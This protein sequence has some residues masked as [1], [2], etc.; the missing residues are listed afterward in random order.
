MNRLLLSFTQSTATASS[1]VFI[2]KS[3]A[4][5]QSYFTTLR[6][7]IINQ[8]A[9]K[10]AYDPKIVEQGK[11]QYWEENG[12]FKPRNVS[13]LEDEE[14]ATTKFSMVLPPP[15]VT[16]SLH[17]G[18]AL[19][20]TIQ[21]SLIR[22]NRMRN[23]E[24]L[25]VPGLDHSG[26]ATQVAVEKSL[27]VKKGL[28]R[29]DLGREKFLEEVYKWTDEYSANINNQLRITGSSLDWSRSVFT[30]DEK[31]NNAVQE[32][33][34][35]FYK[36][37][38][39]YRSTRLVNWCPSLQS[40]ISDIEIDH[41]AIEKPTYVTLKS[42]KKAVEVGVIHNVIYK[43]YNGQGQEVLEDLMVSTTRPETIFGDTA[44]CI[45]PEDPRYKQYHGRHVIHPFTGANIPIIL[46][47][48]LVDP[49]LGT[50][51]V[52]ITPG[53][54]FNDY[55]CGLRHNL[56]MINILNADGTLNENTTPQYKGMD[57]LDAR[58]MV[59][60]T[61]KEKGL[62]HS[63]SPHPTTLAICS[64]SGD[65]LEPV[66]KPQWYVK[67]KDMADRAV[68]YVKSGEIKVVPESF[69]DNWNRW[70]TNIQDWCISR[71]LWWGNPIP[72]Y[73]VIVD[74]SDP[75][76]QER[77]V[78][79]KSLDEAEQ[80]AIEKFNLKKGEFKLEKDLDVLDT[81]FSSGL[82]PISSL[83][84]PNNT[85]Q[86]D[87]KRF[88]QLDILE[89][90]SDI[91]FFWVARMVMMC[92]TLT[93]TPPF[94]TILL[95]PM[96]RDSQ[97]RKMSKSLGNVID[98]LHV[99]NGISLVNL[100]ENVE[101]SNLSPSEK[102]TAIK[103]LEKEFA[104]GIPQCG[105]DSL[106]FSLAQYPINGKDINLDLSKIYGN[107][108]FCNKIWNASKFVMSFIEQ[109]QS[110]DNLI[111]QQQQK[112]NQ[113]L[114]FNYEKSITVI[115]Q[116]ILHR[117][118]NLV[119]Q[120]KESF[121][122]NNLSNASQAIYSF[123]QYDFCDLYIE[124][125]KVDLNLATKKEYNSDS[126]LVLLNVLE[127]FL[128]L[129]HPF[130]PYITEDIW[131]RLPKP[132]NSQDSIMISNFPDSEYSHHS[133][134]N[135]PLIDNHVES[136][137]SLVHHLRSLR[138]SQSIHNHTKFEIQLYSTDSSF[139][140]SIEKLKD[141]FEKLV[142]ASLTINNQSVSTPSSNNATI[143]QFNDN[144][145]FVIDY[146]VE[147]NNQKIANEKKNNNSALQS[148]NS[149]K[150]KLTKFVDEL[151]TQVN[152]PEFKAKASEKLFNSKKEKLENYKKE[153]IE[154][155]EKLKSL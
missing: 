8:D 10:S 110:V 24:T 89:T 53:H 31:R 85:E 155:E 117:L 132:S 71:Q 64:R 153:L 69:Q 87:F 76:Q 35:R 105:T 9:F 125:I 114:P 74:N 20:T 128:R 147:F 143:H 142:N 107:R 106:R 151:E 58:P 124:C 37:G 34:I 42:R 26:I 152:D 127:T 131:Q 86:R 66:L 3:S 55:Q 118:A 96:I 139:N 45:H 2:P 81:W 4:I 41:M 17:I 43:V 111:Y 27:Q 140:Q 77:W 54:D 73:K 150:T 36:M 98:P 32:A 135:N 129:A 83:G 148:L 14:K 113:P 91:L 141:S 108:L 46:D 61:L 23:K 95:H 94:K 72:A 68:D 144:I 122:T 51:V 12:Y 120:V 50:G 48:V 82:F 78:V 19:T 136:F 7:K 13:S 146:D 52:K 80:E 97:G 100:K 1:R 103:G 137:I 119:D 30:L 104:Q 130:M 90:G 75:T 92:S 28:S 109:I 112:D 134:F 70:L 133:K 84:W 79:A 101:T 115:D 18:H 16:G 39:I 21:D 62:Y 49:K 67:C 56:P 47:S 57:R 88:Y 126:P 99:I 123:F 65:L 6:N 29:Y 145:A 154:V 40:V 63:K 93:E 44:V 15:N 5:G 60:E 116:W 25:W 138:K 11:Y 121:A 33:F 22:Y 102:V 38:L 149:K 59:I